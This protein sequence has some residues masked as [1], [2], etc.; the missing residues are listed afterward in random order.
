M[1]EVLNRNSELENKLDALNLTTV[2]VLGDGNC[3]YRAACYKLH[4]NDAGYAELRR[5]VADYL[6]QTGNILGGVISVSPDDGKTFN[7]HIQTL[8]T[9][10]QPVGEDAI[11][12]LANICD[13]EVHIYLAYSEP[14]IYSATDGEKSGEPITLAFYEPGHYRPVLHSQKN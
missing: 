10:G 3:F 13:R 9:D 1:Y 11:I 2:D 6:K 14:L 4:G 8:L 7:E 12:A 5:Q